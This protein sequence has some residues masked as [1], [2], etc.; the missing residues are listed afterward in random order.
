[1]AHLTQIDHMDSICN[2]NSIIV[3][4]EL[5]K[6][7]LLEYWKLS[8]HVVDDITVSK[9]DNWTV[10]WQEYE[11]VPGSM[12]IGE[13]YFCPIRTEESIIDPSSECHTYYA[14]TSL[15]KMYYSLILLLFQ[16]HGHQ[17]YTGD[18]QQHQAESIYSLKDQMNDIYVIC[19]YLLVV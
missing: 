4:V 6:F 7:F 19:F 2:I 13:S 11:N 15:S 9:Q 5:Q 14:N 12:K 17:A 16:L 8:W 18:N 1:M 3:L 10:G